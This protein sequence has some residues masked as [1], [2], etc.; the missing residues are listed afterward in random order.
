MINRLMYKPVS[1]NLT[2]YRRGK[3][4]TI[5]NETARLLI[6]ALSFK[7]EAQEV[8]LKYFPEKLEDNELMEVLAEEEQLLRELRLNFDLTE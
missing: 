1:S 8:L 7:I 2:E 6:N 3:V 5:S 4:M